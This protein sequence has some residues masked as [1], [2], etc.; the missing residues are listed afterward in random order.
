M[1]VFGLDP[2]LNYTGWAVVL[3]KPSGSLSL[4]D[5]GTVCTLSCADLNDKLFSIFSSLTDIIQ[6]FSVSVASIENVFVNLNPF[7][8]MV[9]T[10]TD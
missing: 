8:S 6:K 1:L 4:L 2:G 9:H 10:I 5:C 7:R 3:K